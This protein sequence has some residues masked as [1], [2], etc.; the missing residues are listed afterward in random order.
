M[1]PSRA[2]I[3]RARAAVVA[4]VVTAA[5]AAAVVDMGAA[6]PAAEATTTATPAAPHT[7]SAAAPAAAPRTRKTKTATA[8]ATGG[9]KFRNQIWLK[10]Q[11]T[12]T[13]FRRRKWVAVPVISPK[14]VIG[15]QKNPIG[16]DFRSRRR[17]RVAA[18]DA[19]RHQRR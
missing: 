14:H 4:A 19:Y 15:R 13:R 10:N 5:A 11:K 1:K 8:T 18:E 6:A 16:D 7:S 2:K 12:A 9:T 3:A 17:Q